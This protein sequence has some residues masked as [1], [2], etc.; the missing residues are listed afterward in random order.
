M[1]TDAPR[2]GFCCKFIPADGDAQL[3]R[4][5]NATTVTMAHLNRLA[6]GAAYDKLCTVVAHNLEAVRLQIA[7]VAERPPLERLLRLVSS[8][9]PGYTHPK[10][11]GFYA[12]PALR[13]L[14]ERGLGAAGDLARRAGVRLSMHPGPFCILATLSESALANAVEE[15]DYHAEVMALMGFGGGWHPH[16]AHVNIH[17][18]ARAAGIETFRAN[19]ARV[20][21][22]ARNLVTVENDET[23]YGLDDLLPLGDIVPVVLDLHHHWVAS[24]GEYI[25]PHDPRIARVRESW[26]GVRPVAHVSV[27]REDLLAG[28]DPATRPDFAALLAS[29]LKARDLMAHSDMMWNAAINDLVRRHLAWADFEI[30]AKAKNL[31]SEGLAGA[32]EGR[33]VARAAAE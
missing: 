9:L 8:I 32:I 5:M 26:R 22:T 27:S 15:L 23:S 25:E 16:G 13:G 31:A 14:I 17:V 2:L 7:W 20:S 19:L 28:H 30:E 6:P 29:G 11:R 4:R 1:V 21:A 33:P 24:G 12:D 18:G 3:T 10:V